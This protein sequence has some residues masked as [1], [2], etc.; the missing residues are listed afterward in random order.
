MIYF[1]FL[2]R[3]ISTASFKFWR[4]R[5]QRAAREKTVK[6]RQQRREALALQTQLADALERINDELHHRMG[7][8]KTYRR[9]STMLGLGAPSFGRCRGAK[10]CAPH[11]EH[12]GDFTVIAGEILA[13]NLRAEIAQLRAELDLLKTDLRRKLAQI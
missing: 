2:D 11:V 6:L 13:G 5:P 7:D 10:R 3:A 9:G 1:G 12:Q 8:F 4:R